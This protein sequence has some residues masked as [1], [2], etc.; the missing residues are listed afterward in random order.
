M[1]NLFNERK[2]VYKSAADITINATD[3]PKSTINEI[4]KE[5]SNDN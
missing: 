1:K 3:N 4:L 5:I 2:E